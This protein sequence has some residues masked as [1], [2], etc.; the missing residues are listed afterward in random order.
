MTLPQASPEGEFPS[1]AGE[2]PSLEGVAE[3]CLD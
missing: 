2:L 1:E 3:G